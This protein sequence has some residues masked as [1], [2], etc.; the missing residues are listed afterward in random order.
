MSEARTPEQLALLTEQLLATNERNEHLIE[1]LLVLSESDR[2]LAAQDAA[3]PGRDHRRR[4]SR[5]IAT[6]PTSPASR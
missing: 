3:A 4:W 6:W 5:P 2:G 1:G